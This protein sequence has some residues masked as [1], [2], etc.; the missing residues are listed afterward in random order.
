MKIRTNLLIVLSCF[1]FALL[2]SQDLLAQS[3]KRKKKDYDPP[4]KFGL[5]YT[6]LTAHYNGYFNANE[7]YLGLVDQTNSSYKDNYTE[8]LPIFPYL[9]ILENQKSGG[10][11]DE[12]IKKLGKVIERHRKS[13]WVDDSYLLMAKC[14]MMNGD[15]AAAEESL[16]FLE[17]D[18]SPEAVKKR[19]SRSKKGRDLAKKERD[20]ARKEREQARK[21]KGK[22]SKEEEKPDNYFLKHRP[23]DQDADMTLALLYNFLD[24]PE[25]ATILYSKLERDSKTFK[26]ILTDLEVVKAYGAL[27]VKNHP[28]AIEHLKNS[29]E[30]KYGRKEDRARLAYI[31][32]QL[33]QKQ[34]DIVGAT[35]YFALAKKMTQNYDLIFYAALN[36]LQYK[37]DQSQISYSQVVKELNAM[38]KD[39]KNNEYV[40]SILFAEGKIHLKEKEIDQAIAAFSKA[41]QESGDSFFKKEA[42]SLLADLSFSNDDFVNAK[43]YYDTTLTFMT[44]E[45]EDYSVLKLR[46]DNLIEI[47]QLITEIEMQDSLLKIANMTDAER[48]SLAK[49]IKKERQ[50]E[51]IRQINQQLIER[52]KNSESSDERKKS[53]FFAYSDKAVKKGIKQFE[54]IYGNI[55]LVDNWRVKS[56]IQSVSNSKN[57]EVEGESVNNAELDDIFANVPKTEEEKLKSHQIIRRNYEKLGMQYHDLL[58]RY[59]LSIQVLEDDLL[60]NYNNPN[61][62]DAIYYYLYSSYNN[63]KKTSTAN[64]Y[65]ELLKDKF[66]NSKYTEALGGKKKSTNS[67]IDS[68]ESIYSMFEKGNVSQALKM[69]KRTIPLLEHDDPLLPK[70]SLLESMCIGK[71]EGEE[72]Y[73]ASLNKLVEKHPNSAEAKKAKEIVA[74]ISGASVGIV[75]DS[76]TSGEVP[77]HLKGLPFK[78]DEK[79]PH[80]VIVLMKGKEKNISESKTDISSYNRKNAKDLRLRVSNI[81]IGTD[82]KNAII[83]IRKFPN[84]IAAV[85]YYKRVLENQADFLIGTTNYE[86]YPISQA[87]YKEI[88]K[89]RGLNSYDKFFDYYY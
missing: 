31:T 64:K 66:P 19:Y 73:V 49:Q 53:T 62:L 56:E 68:Y 89:A 86:V 30:Q 88:L 52:A 21:N 14:Y 58:E 1:V 77:S 6:N 50:H 34:N 9:E 23:V 79:A 36:E 37:Y 5:F 29:I 45:D 38:A 48:S 84:Q 40:G 35:E 39:R 12:A 87:N 63:L 44:E 33:L 24:R 57:S 61:H 18:Y 32:A 27:R 74:I 59:D 46:R 81:Y 26:N 72:A 55:P 82:V 76:N 16:L 47:A 43:N 71:K 28:K 10:K 75:S 42:Y 2:P 80:Y 8:V 13:D 83:V 4:S 7:L 51:R 85:K 20:K 69:V 3:K 41:V 70:Y 65:K 22:D 25:D 17:Q 15:F 67:K 11:L 54:K 60:G 78:V